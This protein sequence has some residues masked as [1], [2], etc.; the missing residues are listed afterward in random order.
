V[1]HFGLLVVPPALLSLQV[2]HLTHSN[3]LWALAVTFT[4]YFALLSL[5]IS[6]YR[7]SSSHP[8]AKYPGPFLCKLTKLWSFW[9]AVSGK[10][11]LFY[12]RLHQKY[13]VVV[14]VGKIFSLI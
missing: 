3:F 1:A 5:S 14:R 4:V 10:Q 6:V 11:H 13:G 8:L 2:V 7:L 9:F 12:K